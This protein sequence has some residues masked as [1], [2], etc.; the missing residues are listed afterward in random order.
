MFAA[1]QQ[2]Q[3]AAA[4]AALEHDFTGY[5]SKLLEQQPILQA[6]E[7]IDELIYGQVLKMHP[8]T[9]EEAKQF[10]ANVVDAYGEKVK[11]QITTAQKVAAVSAAKATNG[12]A[13]KGSASPIVPVAK[14]YNKK[15]GLHDPELD[16]DVMAFLNSMGEGV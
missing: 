2:A 14:T 10:A 16:K 6:M 12:I 1:Q 9:V 3:H 5:T 15:K 7:G 4:T 11:A 8:S 13:P